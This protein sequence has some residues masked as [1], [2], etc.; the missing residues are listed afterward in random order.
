MTARTQALLMLS[1]HEQVW[2]MDTIDKDSRNPRVFIRIHDKATMVRCNDLLFSVPVLED[3]PRSGLEKD[4]L[5]NLHPSTLRLESA[6][7]YLLVNGMTKNRRYDFFLDART[8]I[9]RPPCRRQ[10]LRSHSE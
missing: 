1:F 3:T 6:G 2:S 9:R 7:L 4:I 10:V 8:A 5:V